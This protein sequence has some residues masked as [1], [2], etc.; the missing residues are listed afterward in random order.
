MSWSGRS[1]LTRC[2]AEKAKTS[3]GTI[4]FR[5]E[6]QRT[7]DEYRENELLLQEN[8]KCS[9]SPAVAALADS[10]AQFSGEIIEQMSPLLSFLLQ[11]GA[12]LSSLM[13]M[14]REVDLSLDWSQSGKQELNA[15]LEE[16][17]PSV[18]FSNELCA[19]YFTYMS[20]E[21]GAHFVLFDDAGSIRKK[22]LTAQ[23]LGIDRAVLS[24]PQ[25]ADLLGDVV[26]GL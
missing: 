7:E 14:D 25:T 24:Y 19:H 17:R 4:S 18:F 22:L 16:R 6:L 13:G 8:V 21:N 10:G 15:L 23:A 11:G 2:P 12:Y 9:R 5:Q 20:R 1:R 3:S 26:R